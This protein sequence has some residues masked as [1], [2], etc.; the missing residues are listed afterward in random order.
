L[1]TNLFAHG[2]S[3][4]E[5]AYITELNFSHNL[6]HFDF[7]RVLE[8]DARWGKKWISFVLKR[9]MHRTW[10]F[11]LFACRANDG[12]LG[13]LLHHTPRSLFLRIRF[14]PLPPCAGRYTTCIISS[15]YRLSTFFFGCSLNLCFFFHVR[16]TRWSNNTFCKHV[17][18]L[19]TQL[20][21][22]L[23][24]FEVILVLYSIIGLSAYSL[25]RYPS[26]VINPNDNGNRKWFS[27]KIITQNIRKHYR[28]NFKCCPQP[29]G[30]VWCNSS[31]EASL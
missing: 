31:D 8:N 20:Q 3:T 25:T 21:W 6:R 4:H 15:L 7:L 17:G 13:L 22:S 29:T 18:K 11:T 26:T 24:S 23:Q 9:Q 12:N 28:E 1:G 10:R 2:F 16:T 14:Q 19:K 30:K 27:G 5:A